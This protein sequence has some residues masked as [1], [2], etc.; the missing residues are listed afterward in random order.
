MSMAYERYGERH[1]MLCY[2]VM[3][4]AT[5]VLCRSHRVA[6]F[7]AARHAILTHA[8]ADEANR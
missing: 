7:D 1:I 6:P 2:V 5:Y 3:L 8:A 4:L